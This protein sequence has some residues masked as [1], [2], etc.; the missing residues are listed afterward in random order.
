MTI[1]AA[2]VLVWSGVHLSLALL[3]RLRPAAISRLGEPAF[4][5]LFSL[6]IA[7]SLVL[8]V[9]GWRSAPPIPVYDTPAW[10]RHLAVT[11]MPFAFILF[12][13]S[14]FN[15]NLRRWLRHPQLIGVIVWG[16]AHLASN[17]DRR[18]MVLFG[19]MTLWA[20]AEIVLINRRDGAPARAA[21][22]SPGLD[23]ISVL[24]GFAAYFIVAKLHPW[25]T[26]VPALG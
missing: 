20:L 6:L 19:G 17:G 18:S 10:G 15:T 2:G 16:I 4:K 8:I 7:L 14:G 11:L 23:G 1:L 5:G 9:L 24:A 25:F 13:A 12:A 22:V 21:P 3:P 26:G